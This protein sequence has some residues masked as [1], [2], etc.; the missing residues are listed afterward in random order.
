MAEARTARLVPPALPRIFESL[1]GVFVDTGCNQHLS[2]L[3]DHGV[4]AGDVVRTDRA[5]GKYDRQ[6]IESDSFALRFCMKH[7]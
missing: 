7:F 5:S 1:A 3:T 6:E 4:R 2:H